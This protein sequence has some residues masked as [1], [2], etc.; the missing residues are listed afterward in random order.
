ML[1]QF[2]QSKLDVANQHL[3]I[4]GHQKELTFRETKLLQYFVINT[5]QLLK[6]EDLLENVWGNEGVI[7]GRSLDVF[8]SRLRKALKADTSLQ[9][10]TV[11]GVGYRMEV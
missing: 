3:Y 8:V 1:L 6:R 4:N 9:I 7:V 10:K 2:G 5:N 11:H